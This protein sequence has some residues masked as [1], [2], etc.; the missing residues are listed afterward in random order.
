M[1]AALF[2]ILL[3][4]MRSPDKTSCTES[5]PT[6]LPPSYITAAKLSPLPPPSHGYGSWDSANVCSFPWDPNPFLFLKFG[7]SSPQTRLFLFSAEDGSSKQ[8]KSLRHRGPDSSYK[9]CQNS[10]WYSGQHRWTW[11][12]FVRPYL[13]MK[14]RSWRHNFKH[15]TPDASRHRVPPSCIRIAQSRDVGWQLCIFV[16][17]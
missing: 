1:L 7:F 15:S 3:A 6:P 11:W 17:L 4:I 12:S 16:R 13:L 9:F 14:A 8:F 5:A 10:S 2:G